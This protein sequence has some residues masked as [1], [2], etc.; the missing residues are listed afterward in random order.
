MEAVNCHCVSLSLQQAPLRFHPFFIPLQHSPCFTTFFKS[1]TNTSKT[2][3]IT[4]N[5]VLA[6]SPAVIIIIPPP[7]LLH[8]GKLHATL[9]KPCL[10]FSSVLSQ[11]PSFSVFLLVLIPRITLFSRS[12]I[13]P[14]FVTEVATA[15]GE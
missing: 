9:S 12:K 1:Q 11:H 7:F 2:T 15:R 5:I 13:K 14:L 10:L 6:L 8:P 4:S 3:V